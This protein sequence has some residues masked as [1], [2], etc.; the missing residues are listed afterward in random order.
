MS[1]WCSAR[2]KRALTSRFEN[3]SLRNGWRPF[4]RST[5]LLQAPERIGV[6]KKVLF[7]AE[8][9]LFDQLGHG[10]EV[11]H[12]VEPYRLSPALVISLRPASVFGR[13]RMGATRAYGIGL[14]TVRLQLIL[15]AD[16]V[17]PEIAHVV[18]VDKLGS[19]A[20]SK[21]G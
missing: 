6:F 8:Q 7:A 11:V 15:D 18:F 3:P 1:T 9:R 2:R 20:K 17:P 16:L 4:I 19:L 5:A 12:G 13:T 14:F 10:G 21:A